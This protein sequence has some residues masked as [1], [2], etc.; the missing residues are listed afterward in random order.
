MFIFFTTLTFIDTRKSTLN[1]Y[2]DKVHHVCIVVEQLF[3]F[4]VVSG[5]VG[6][7]VARGSP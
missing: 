4:P 3:C 6:S 1:Y 2:T 7:C 5:Y